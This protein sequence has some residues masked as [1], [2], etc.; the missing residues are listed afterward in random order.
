MIEYKF[1]HVKRGDFLLVFLR[2]LS[3]DDF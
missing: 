3:Y 2:F 1:V